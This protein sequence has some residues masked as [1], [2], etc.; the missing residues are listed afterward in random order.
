MATYTVYIS[1]NDATDDILRRVRAALDK[2][3]LYNCNLSGATIDIDV[4]D[5]AHIESSDT[6][7]DI[8]A[9]QLLYLVENVVDEAW[10][11]AWGDA[12]EGVDYFD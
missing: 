1:S 5:Y 8:T 6:G 10:G 2:E 11:R 9:V 3:L 7:D 12:P 4:D